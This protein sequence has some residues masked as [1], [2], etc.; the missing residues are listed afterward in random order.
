MDDAVNHPEHYNKFGFEVYDIVS[1]FDFT[2]GNVLK[3]LLRA[4][5][6]GKPLEDLKKAKWYLNHCKY[7]FGPLQPRNAS[8]V[9]EKLSKAYEQLNRHENPDSVEIICAKL[10]KHIID[11][12][13]LERLIKAEKKTVKK[14][15]YENNCPYET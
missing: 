8:F 15:G 5:Y 12:I 14:G 10:I 9:I 1:L 13:D 4:P 7:E 6:K 3:Y 2:Q 11:I